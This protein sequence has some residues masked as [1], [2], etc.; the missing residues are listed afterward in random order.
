MKPRKL[1]RRQFLIGTSTALAGAALACKMGGGRAPGTSPS[2]TASPAT[3]L[4]TATPVAA[5]ATPPLQ[6]T[7]PPDL[8]A[9]LVLL[10]G[11]VLTIDATDTIAQAIAVKDGLI[12]A[13]GADGDIAPF[14]GEATRVIQLNGRTVTPGLIDAHNHFQVMGLINSYYVPLL[15]PDVITNEDLQAKLAE[16]VA[17]TP[18]GEWINGYFLSIKGTGLPSRYDLD[19]VSPN[20]PVWITQQGGHYGTANTRALELANITSG[21]PDPPGGM[22]G[23]DS[24]GELTG[25]FYNHRAMDLVRQHVPLY[26]QEMV[27]DNILSTQKLFAAC[28][29]TSF[30]DNNVRGVETVQ[31]YMNMAREG[32]MYLRGAIYYTLE[33]P[34]DI[35]R[36]LNEMDTYADGFM[37]FAGYKF[38]LDGQLTMAYCHEPHNGDRWDMPTWDPQMFKDAVQSLHDTGY[39]ICV[40]CAGDA[41]TDLTLDAYEAA[42]A[43]NTRSDPRH[44]I[45]HAVFTRPESTL[46]M[47]DL[48]VVV[49][50]QPQFIRLCGDHYAELMG[51]ARAKRAIVTREWLENGV[52]VALGS[53]CPSTPWYTP[54][55]TL[56]GAVARPTYTNKPYE[57]EQGLTIQ[58]ALR[59][60]TM[61]SAYAGHEENEKGSL[62][63]GKLADMAI[64]DTDLYTATLQEMWNMNAEMTIVGGEVVHDTGSLALRRG[65]DLADCC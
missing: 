11:K 16:I 24:R 10:S 6:P 17:Q 26:T 18:E 43:A 5:A 9:D 52:V 12:Q 36:A 65:K 40:H 23:R 54:H 8:A 37:R 45:E 2:T 14:I 47:K 35:E 48:G 61:G 62:E 4:S 56:I 38:L 1:T 59:A 22:I 28:G 49:C 21:T 29:V 39:Q 25:I 27:R 53:D 64:W 57:P 19:P 15:P 34:A 44:R 30:H 55:A 3:S 32:L 46:R 58:E 42:M 7:A 51:E 41:A 63:A 20:H 33:W 50:T 60:H 31:S 13:V